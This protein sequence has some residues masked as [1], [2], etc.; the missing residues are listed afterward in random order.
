M[1]R[2]AGGADQLAVAKGLLKKGKT[3]E[4]LRVAQVGAGQKSS[5]SRSG[6]ARGWGGKLPDRLAEEV[7]AFAL[8]RPLRRMFQDEARFGRISDVRHCWD[9]KPHRPMVRAMVTQQYTYAYGAAVSP[10]DG[11]FDSLI[12][13]SV[14]GECMP[15]S[16]FLEEMAA[17]YP[18]ENIVMV[19][20]GAGWHKNQDIKLP[21]NL[22]TVFLPAYSP[23]INPQEHVWM[24][25]RTARSVASNAPPHRPPDKRVS[26]GPPLFR[27]GLT[28]H[29]ALVFSAHG[30]FARWA[31]ADNTHQGCDGRRRT[32]PTCEWSAVAQGSGLPCRSRTWRFQ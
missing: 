22:R 2:K 3:D 15:L 27:L 12:L 25:L 30:R 29:Q 10:V 8:S 6:R 32:N 20:D 11:R 31:S 18:D 17:R 21:E 16:L 4:E 5:Q 19:L 26:S 14:S 24:A 1:A 23:E 9:K 13:P 28:Q 7:A